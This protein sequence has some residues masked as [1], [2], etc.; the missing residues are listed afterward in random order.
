M[1]QESYRNRE[2]QPL[3]ERA[4]FG[5][6]PGENHTQLFLER[7][8][9]D[10][11]ITQ[12]AGLY[13]RHLQTSRYPYRAFLDMP[14]SGSPE[15]ARFEVSHG[16]MDDVKNSADQIPL[17]SYLVSGR[18]EDSLKAFLNQPQDVCIAALASEL[19]ILLAHTSS[20]TM[21][22]PASRI[23][24]GFRGELN[25]W[26]GLSGSGEI[27]IVRTCKE[28]FR[29]YSNDPII[30]NVIERSIIE[31]HEKGHGYARKHYGQDY[32]KREG[33]DVSRCS[34]YPL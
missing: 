6:N 16:S 33:V 19:I 29:E 14:V 26:T 22:E 8:G 20:L 32:G 12:L 9:N 1:Q 7:I 2:G 18:T 27:G 25:R 31:A 11:A 4:G 13:Y 5:K 24:V 21:F 15:N 10:H 3:H 17:G 23:S 30:L 34:A 28:I